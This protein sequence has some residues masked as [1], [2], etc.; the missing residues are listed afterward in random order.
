MRSGK[1]QRDHEIFDSFKAK[2]LLPEVGKT[3]GRK[4][5][6]GDGQWNSSVVG[7]GEQTQMSYSTVW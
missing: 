3:V 4:R 2:V 7:L 6:G 1:S 5:R